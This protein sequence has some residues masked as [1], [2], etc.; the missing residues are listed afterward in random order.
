[1]TSD[2]HS[3]AYIG[4]NT[5]WQVPMR[6]ILKIRAR[7][8]FSKTHN[9]L[10]YCNKREPGCRCF[11]PNSCF[12]ALCR[13]IT[14]PFT[15]CLVGH[16][17]WPNMP[18]K[19]ANFSC[20]VTVVNTY[21]WLCTPLRYIVKLSA[22]YLC[23]YIGDVNSGSSYIPPVFVCCFDCKA[24]AVSSMPDHALVTSQGSVVKDSKYIW[25]C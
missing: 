2:P 7:H 22:T 12:V 9:I 8:C 11:A 15:A 25:C 4:W 10:H 16:M 18:L 5:L 23:T 19:V 24:A 21:L 17:S 13:G 20:R 3:L 6:G 14:G 1:M